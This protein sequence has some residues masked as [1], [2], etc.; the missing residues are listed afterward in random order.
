MAFLYVYEQSPGYFCVTVHGGTGFWILLKSLLHQKCSCVLV[1]REEVRITRTTPSRHVS[2]PQEKKKS[3]LEWF[4]SP[5]ESHRK[6]Y[7]R[8]ERKE[9]YR[10]MCEVEL[11]VW[12][13]EPRAAIKW[14][15]F[16]LL[17]FPP[18][19]RVSQKEREGRAKGQSVGRGQST[20]CH[21]FKRLQNYPLVSIVC[22]WQCGLSSPLCAFKW[23]LKTKRRTGFEEFVIDLMEEGGRERGSGCGHDRFT[24][25]VPDF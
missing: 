14:R 24:P 11:E 3:P 1:D 15:F 21:V 8:M 23:D 13:F 19:R 2:L 20:A 7:I 12:W 17:S 22:N 16:P 5:L 10:W 18:L 25:F 6:A 4:L 9:V